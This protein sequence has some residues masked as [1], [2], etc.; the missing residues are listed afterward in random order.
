MKLKKL[1]LIL[2][3]ILSIAIIPACKN[4]NDEI[5]NNN[6]DDN[7]DDNTIVEDNYFLTINTDEY[8]IIVDDTLQLEVNTN[9]KEQLLWETSDPEVATV[10]ENGLVT[11]KKYGTCIISATYDFYFIEVAVTVERKPPVKKYV[12]IDGIDQFEIEYTGMTFYYYLNKAYGSRMFK[13]FNDLKFV[14]YYTDANF[15]NPLDFQEKVYNNVTI[16]AKYD[17]DTTECEEMLGITETLLH[18]TTLTDDDSIKVFTPDYGT[19]TSYN[20]LTFSDYFFAVVEY[21]TKTNKKIVTKTY[22]DGI[23]ND[24]K[25]PYN[26]FIIAVPKGNDKYLNCQDKLKYGTEIDLDTYSIINATKLYINK[27]K[28]NV[29]LEQLNLNLNA[30]FVSVY[31]V[32]NSQFLY[33]KASSSKAYPASTTKVIT[34]LAALQYAELD[35]IFTIGD[36]LDVMYEGDSPSTAKLQ[37]GQKWSL[38]HLLYAMLLPSGN[39]ASYSIA[40]GVAKQIP[41]NENKSTRELL[42]YFNDLMNDVRDEV[43]ATNS[44]FM[45]PDGNSYYNYVPDKQWDDRITNHYVTADDMIKFALLAFNYGAIAKVTSTYSSSFTIESGE[46]MPYSNTNSLLNIGSSYY[47]KHAVGLKTGTTNPAGA[48]LIAGADYNGRFV[49]AAIMNNSVSSNRYVDALSIFNSIF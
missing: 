38:R 14:G 16:Y 49:I 36:E 26:G 15:E 39:D 35:D 19:Y 27:V 24:I 22:T 5:P 4:S 29:S 3:L 37:K 2:L 7:N 43:G 45:V 11:A 46:K 8:S 23:K 6:T 17:K 28:Q 10:D 25:I 44:N 47:Y 20:D 42:D 21:Q 33:Q 12:I 13:P 1:L 30:K 31:D 41:G 18:E 40:A 48:C 34:A 9:I 32:T